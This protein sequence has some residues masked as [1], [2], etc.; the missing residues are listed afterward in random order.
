MR[1]PDSNLGANTTDR[2]CKALKV[3]RTQVEVRDWLE[4]NRKD[5]GMYKLGKMI[6]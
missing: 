6:I 5:M 2:L 3:G 1:I 4:S